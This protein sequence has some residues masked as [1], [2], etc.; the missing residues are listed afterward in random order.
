MME[1]MEKRDTISNA[2]GNSKSVGRTSDGSFLINELQLLTAI[3]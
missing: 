2:F 1:Q 3:Y